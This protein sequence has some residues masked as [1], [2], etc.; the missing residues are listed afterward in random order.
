VADSQWTVYLVQLKHRFY[1]VAYSTVRTKDTLLDKGCKGHF[2]KYTV[3]SVEERV[4]VVYVLF[5]F[6]GTLV[7]EPHTSID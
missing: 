5:K 3:R 1:I 6:A 2:L 7:A 4:L